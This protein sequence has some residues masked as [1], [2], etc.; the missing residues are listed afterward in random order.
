MGR[1]VKRSDGKTIDLDLAQAEAYDSENKALKTTTT[2]NVGDIEI[3]AVEIKDGTS[4]QRAVIDS[5]G[6]IKTTAA[7]NSTATGTIDAAEETVECTISPGA[8]TVGIQLTGTWAG[9]G[10]LVIFEATVDGTNWTSIY[11]NL[12]SA[13]SIAVIVSGSNGLYQMA[14]AGYVK[15]RVRGYTWGTPGSCSV[16]FNSTVGSSASLLALP[17]PSGS[18]VIG[19]VGID[20]TTVGTT[21]AVSLVDALGTISSDNPLPV[22][23]FASP[24]SADIIFDGVNEAIV[25]TQNNQPL[26]EGASTSNNQALILT[27][28]GQK[29]EP[30]DSQM[31]VTQGLVERL[32]FNALKKLNVDSTGRLRV[33]AESVASHA[34]TL[35]STVVSAITAWG[36][37]TATSKSQWESQLQFEQG[38]RKNLVIS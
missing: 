24:E 9:V 14:A 31:T 25:V 17:L 2:V 21:N 4:D 33:S 3:G 1:N 26:P 7:A 12:T 23:I 38:F 8:S 6:A 10:D 16:S 13:G 32:V 19:K 20:Q 37:T 34:V 5:T 28:L 11:A 36:L 18:N 35:S 27:E 22:E 29:T 15:V 30:N